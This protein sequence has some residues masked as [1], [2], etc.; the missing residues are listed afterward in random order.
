MSRTTTIGLTLLL[1]G[2]IS[3][4]AGAHAVRRF[5]SPGILGSG[6][7]TVQAGEA[8]DFN[9]TLQ[10]ERGDPPT[11]VLLHLLDANGVIVARRDAILEPGKSAT[12]RHRLPG[13]LR[14]Q[15]QIVNTV[16]PVGSTSLLISTIEIFSSSDPTS[17]DPGLD[18]TGRRRFVCSSDDPALPGRIPDQD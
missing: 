5:A 4:A 17:L 6:L 18:A 11:R 16:A 12:L 7:F 15:A 3:G 14:A 2:V 10:A 9:V 1:V 8:V 13:V